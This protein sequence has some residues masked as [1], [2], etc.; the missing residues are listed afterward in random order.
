MNLR[1]GAAREP[2]VR[3]GDCMQK[4]ILC[5]FPWLTMGGA[6]RLHLDLVTELH[7]RG[8]RID[9]ITSLPSSHPWQPLF[10]P[11]CQSITHLGAAAPAE[12]P[13]K[14]LHHLADLQPEY[15]FI[16]N[17]TLGY[18]LLPAMRHACPATI[19]VDLS[20]AIDPA[21]ARGGYPALSLDY[22]KELDL[23]ATISATLRTWMLDHHGEPARIHTCLAGVDTSLWDPGHFDRGT[24]RATLHIPQKAWVGLFPARLEAVKRPYLALRLMAWLVARLPHTY[25]LIAGDGSYA[26]FVR[27][28]LRSQRLEERIRV[29]GMVA[30]ADMPQWYAISDV[31]LL[32]SQMEGLSVAIYE[33]MAMGLVPVSVAAGGQAELVTPATGFLI[34]RSAGEERAYQQALYQLASNPA[35][36]AAM[37]QAGRERILASYRRKHYADRFEQLLQ[38]ASVLQQHTP[39]LISPPAVR[40]HARQLA[41]ASAERDAAWYRPKSTT[42]TLRS[43]LRDAYWRLVE[44]GAWWLVPLLDRLRGR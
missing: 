31:L 14:L 13:Q 41:I 3:A 23:Q 1:D 21:D 25:F 9:I 2:P 33:A 8:W 6:D 44:A 36:L 15:L 18:H 19:F 29:L 34:A 4:Q 22:A 12:Q 5:L 10:A 11:Y 20:H 27:G 17:C 28:Y 7:Q 37:G 35:Q 42:P 24:L 30:A 43:R 26:P 40:D 16:S 39:R 32:P 38:Q